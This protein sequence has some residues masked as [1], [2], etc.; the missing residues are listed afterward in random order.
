[1]EKSFDDCFAAVEIISKILRAP[2]LLLG[3]QEK[4]ATVE[5]VRRPLLVDYK[6]VCVVAQIETKV[7]C[8]ISRS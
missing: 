5:I 8:G 1:V 7:G 3:A 4:T 6:V 2:L